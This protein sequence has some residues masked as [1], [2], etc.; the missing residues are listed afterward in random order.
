VAKYLINAIVELP[1]DDLE[2]KDGHYAL[3]E[4]ELVPA[5]DVLV[6]ERLGVDDPD[7]LV[8]HQILWYESVRLPDET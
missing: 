7:S 1:D 2:V 4:D 5:I 6:S 8:Q 3:D